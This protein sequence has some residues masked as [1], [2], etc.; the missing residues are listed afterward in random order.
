[1]SIASLVWDPIPWGGDAPDN[2]VY[3][4]HN[5]LQSYDPDG[6]ECLFWAFRKAFLSELPHTQRKMTKS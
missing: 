2:L 4:S 3:A 5:H 1:M 6:V